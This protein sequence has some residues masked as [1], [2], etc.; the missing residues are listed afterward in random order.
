VS[1]DGSQ[2]LSP[3][4]LLLQELTWRCAGGNTKYCFEQVAK[5]FDSDKHFIYRLFLEMKVDIK[6]VL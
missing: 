2:L 6:E 4:V 3:P 1:C 5:T